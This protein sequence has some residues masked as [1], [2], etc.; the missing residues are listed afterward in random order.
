MLISHSYLWIFETCTLLFVY[1]YIIKKNEYNICHCFYQL[2]EL[3]VSLNGQI[4]EK[5][6]I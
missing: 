6:F 2:T 3:I 4:P 5:Q 1:D